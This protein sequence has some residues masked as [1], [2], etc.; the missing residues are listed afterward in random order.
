MT[1]SLPEI[2]DQLYGLPPADFTP[3]RDAL[4]KEHKADKELA[5]QVKA[6]KKPS[7]AARVVNLL[8]RR[9]APRVEQVLAVGGSAAG[10]PEPTSTARSCGLSLGSAAS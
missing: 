2:A 3:A 4:A 6:L 8:V 7:L 5:A 1:D 9:D 10:G